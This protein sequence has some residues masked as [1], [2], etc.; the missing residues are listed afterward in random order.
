MQ[1][2][3]FLKG[4]F[5]R[6][7][8]TV[9]QLCLNIVLTR[10]LGVEESGSFFFVTNAL[11]FY[12]LLSSLNIEAGIGFY[13]ARKQITTLNLL[14]VGLAFA[15]LS[16]F[17]LLFFQQ[18]DL[19][20][21]YLTSA[22]WSTFF[23]FFFVAGNLISAIFCVL[24]YA[25]NEYATPNILMLFCTVVLT[26]F[27]LTVIHYRLIDK[28]NVICIYFI[29]LLVQSVI[30]AFVF[31]AKRY[32]EVF[33]S[34]K[35]ITKN[36]FK[37][38]LRFSLIAL[39]N[40]VVFFLLY[41]ADYWLVEHYS[42]AGELANYIQ[43]SKFGQFLLIMPNIFSAIVLPRIADGTVKK[44]ARPAG[45]AFVCMTFFFLI[46]LL[47]L[48]LIGPKFFISLLGTGFSPAFWP[49]VIKIPA[50][51]FLSCSFVIGTWFSGTDKVIYN[52]VCSLAGLIILIAAD[53]ILIPIYGI[54][55][56]SI[57]SLIAYM[58][59]LLVA[60]FLYQKKTSQNWKEI[61]NFLAAF[62]KDWKGYVKELLIYLK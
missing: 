24:F 35:L 62:R 2:K 8:Y 52:T 49:A 47:T 36:E 33:S 30:L 56:A 58:S 21:K 5:W 6:A 28:K 23:S 22:Q 39:L 60:A 13:A 37:S 20:N 41:R 29:F 40:N 18:Q 14:R 4:F 51:L 25:D 15:F 57:G 31:S 3:R 53:C 44:F 27:F 59:V 46:L 17:L 48:F 11:A 43:A 12:L 9:S 38:L 26:V 55:G 61:W 19:L 45:L 42:S 16:C 54:I 7:L 32:K 50:I 10:L 34:Q 1:A